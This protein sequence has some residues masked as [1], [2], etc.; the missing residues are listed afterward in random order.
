MDDSFAELA[1]DC[2]RMCHVLKA[3][4]E[5]RDVD[6]LS[7]PSSGQLEDLGRCVH[8]TQMPSLALTSGSRVVRHIESAVSERANCVHSSREYHP[9]STKQCLI[10]CIRKLVNSS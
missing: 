5:G 8:W 3:A 1:M 10:M 6:G 4:T 2:V 9:E 7:G